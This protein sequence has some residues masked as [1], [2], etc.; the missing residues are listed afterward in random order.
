MSVVGCNRKGC[1]SPL[2]ERYSEYYGYICNDCYKEL[3]R[4]QVVSVAD[5]MRTSPKASLKVDYS[6]IFKEIYKG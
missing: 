4:G 3:Q 1:K 2:C 6:S 5:F